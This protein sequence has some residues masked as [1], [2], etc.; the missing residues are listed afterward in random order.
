MWVPGSKIKN[1]LLIAKNI[2]HTEKK[3]CHYLKIAPLMRH[4]QRT[5]NLKRPNSFY[6]WALYFQ[7]DYKRAPHETLQTA[8]HQDE[9]LHCFGPLIVPQSWFCFA[10]LTQL[11][12]VVVVVVAGKRKGHTDAVVFYSLQQK[13]ELKQMGLCFTIQAKKGFK[14]NIWDSSTEIHLSIV[15]LEGDLKMIQVWH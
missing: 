10:S 14:E 13:G 4:E 5:V 12:I 3:N 9:I 7:W 11:W 15:I 2:F 6:F 8:E 1:P